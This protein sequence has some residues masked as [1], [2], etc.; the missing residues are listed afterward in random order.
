MNI[1]KRIKNYFK[2]RGRKKEEMNEKIKKDVITLKKRAGDLRERKMLAGVK[3]NS[4]NHWL[5]QDYIIR[6]QMSTVI[7]I[8][9]KY[10][11]LGICKFNIL[12]LDE[13]HNSLEEKK[14]SIRDE[15]DFFTKRNE[16]SSN[17][18]KGISVNTFE[19]LL[20]GWYNNKYLKE[21]RKYYNKDILREFG[22]VDL[23]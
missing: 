17:F 15:I 12:N 11:D 9:E 21:Y 3:R 14:E 6:D 4:S 10:Y 7:Y 16:T 5:T 2:E 13:I 19:E 1:F 23:E 8:L 22:F 18:F 20:R